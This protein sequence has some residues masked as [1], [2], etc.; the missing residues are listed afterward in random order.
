MV[1]NIIYAQA[2]PWLLFSSPKPAVL[3][4]ENFSSVYFVL[5]LAS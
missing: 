4:G 1:S 2:G 5:L 3:K